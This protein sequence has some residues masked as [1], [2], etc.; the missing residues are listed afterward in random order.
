MAREIPGESSTSF[1][2]A[3]TDYLWHAKHILAC[4]HIHHLSPVYLYRL[5]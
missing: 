5:G 2:E 1:D 3:A 4:P